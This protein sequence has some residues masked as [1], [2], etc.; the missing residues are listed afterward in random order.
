MSIAKTEIKTLENQINKKLVTYS[1]SFIMTVHF[2]RDR[3]NDSRNNPPITIRELADIFDR[4]IDKYILSIVALDNE[5]TFNIKCS[6]TH[7]NI[8]CAVVKETIESTGATSHKNIMITIMRK[9]DFKSHD[10]VE[11]IV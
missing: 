1:T 4:L 3:L 2:V 7:I 9:K 6:T 11:F 8:P 5:D 10:L